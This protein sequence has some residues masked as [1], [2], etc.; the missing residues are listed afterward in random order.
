MG[1][2]C[3]FNKKNGKKHRGTVAPFAIKFT[4]VTAIEFCYHGGEL[5]ITASR[6]LRHVSQFT[7]GL[8]TQSVYIYV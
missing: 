5:L 4:F 7:H 6:S 8:K 2:D 1:V 3:L